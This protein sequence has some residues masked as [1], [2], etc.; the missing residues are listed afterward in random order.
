M[1]SQLAQRIAWAEEGLCTHSHDIASSSWKPH[2][3]HSWSCLSSAQCYFSSLARRRVQ[4]YRSAGQG[5]ASPLG[6]IVFKCC[7]ELERR[8]GRGLGAELERL[9]KVKGSLCPG[10]HK[11]WLCIKISKCERKWRWQ[12]ELM[13]TQLPLGITVLS[14]IALCTWW[15][16]H[17]YIKPRRRNTLL[18]C[19]H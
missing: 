9:T 13:Q 15:F 12:N 2:K 19:C 14:S 8:Y 10:L 16:A 17:L 18:G 4:A 1:T 6:Q 5:G 7:G 3:H 11:E